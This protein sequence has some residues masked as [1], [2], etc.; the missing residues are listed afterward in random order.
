MLSKVLVLR[1]SSIGD[2]ILTSPFL[3]AFKVRFPEAEL[4][5]VVRK[6]Y[7]DLLRWNP[8][9]D[10]LI[11]V[12]VSQG[13]RGLETLNLALCTEHFDAVFDLHHHLRTRIIRNGVS[14]HIHSI[15]KRALR[16]LLLVGAHLN[17]YG[18]VVP[19]PE[20]YIETAARYGVVADTL[21]PELFLPD[22]VLNAAAALLSSAGWAASSPL[23]G[24]CPG[25]Q[26]FTKRWP[27]E[28]F[29][30]LTRLLLA[31]G[32]DIAVFGSS[33]DTAAAEALQA[34]DSSRVL[35]LCGRASLAE[36]AAM[37]ASCEA[38]VAND[39]GLMHMATALRR[40]VVAVFGSTVKEF[41]FF[42]YNSKA[43]VLE[44][45]DLPCRPCT[46]IGRKSCP[47]GHFKCM[48]DVS[49][50]MVLEALTGLLRD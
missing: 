16:R 48:E 36:T 13:R 10:N 49:P 39:S 40:P 3:R 8:H 14:G 22:D 23:I 37:L 41:G 42:P 35:M 46:F 19:V 33:D 31:H 9:I 20:R 50:E 47:K 43:A 15:D 32:Y 17:T 5:Y 21:G 18:T 29:I 7:A 27:L 11:T 26:H 30:Q 44:V 6:E 28:K 2:I 1:L 25:S 4:H 34:V 12:D 24:V 38:V 45:R